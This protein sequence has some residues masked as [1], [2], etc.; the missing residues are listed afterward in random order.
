MLGPPSRGEHEDISLLNAEIRRARKV[1]G[2]F[3]DWV[4]IIIYLFLMYGKYMG[5]VIVEGVVTS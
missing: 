4:D 1:R 5:D 3:E 2:V